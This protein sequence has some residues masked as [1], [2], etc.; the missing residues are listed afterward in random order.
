MSAQT[1]FDKIWARHTVAEEEGELLLYVDR[2]LIHEGSS[3]A[4]AALDLQNRKVFRPQQVFAFNDHYVPT[5]GRDK[6]VAGIA[7]PEIRDMVIKLAANS[8]QHGVRLFGIDDPQQGILHIV[9]PELGITQP[10]LF[11]VGAD[12]HTSTHGAFGCLAF[13]VGA[14]EMMH[15][16]ATQTIWQRKP[17]TMRIV[18]DGAL[19]TGVTAKD[20]IL[21]IIARIGAGGATGHVI[22]YAGAAIKSMTMEARMTVCNMS[23]EAGGRAGM[24][25]PDATT[26]EYMAGRP[27]APAG[28]AWDDA[29]AVWRALPS[30]ADAQFDKV[31][32]LDAAQI[33]PMVTWGT[34]PEHAL[35]INGVVPDPRDASD[36]NKSAEISAALDYMALKPGTRLADIAVDRIFIGSCTNSRIEDLRAAA[37]IAKLGRAKVTA[38]VVPGSR[39]V[40]RQAEQE[41]LDRIFTAAG[42]EWRDPGCSLCTAI[43]GDQLQPGER[44]ASTS[45]R[46]FKGRQGTGG[47]TH[48]VSPAMAAAAALTGHL[49]DVRELA[50]KG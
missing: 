10:G 27:Y 35:P 39:T 7:I 50:R 33:A 17:K 12:S 15:V 2:A 45:N 25:A 42:F 36:G 20:V 34:S 32:Q 11:I 4:Y 23:I 14:S 48:L 8:A 13:G 21:A 38:W 43:N 3:H 40:Q 6:G 47:R 37:E 31:V 9:P 49:T 28:K 22:E 18:V 19:G 46:N 29:M 44:C 16:M 24:I 26:F 5:S 30:D 1:M 41:G